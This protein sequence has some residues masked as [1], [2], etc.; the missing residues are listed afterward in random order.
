MLPPAGQPAKR[1]PESSP[2]EDEDKH[3]DKAA[4]V[5]DDAGGESSGT[6]SNRRAQALMQETC[7]SQHQG[8]L[9]HHH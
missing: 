2:G 4:K 1:Q 5:D 9:R 7:W 3:E 6:E 8:A